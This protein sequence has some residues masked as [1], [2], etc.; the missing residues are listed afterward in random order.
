M[1]ANSWSWLRCAL[2]PIIG[3]NKYCAKRP[4]TLGI[5]HHLVL[6]NHDFQTKN[7]FCLASARKANLPTAVLRSSHFNITKFHTNPSRPPMDFPASKHC[8]FNVYVY[9]FLSWLNTFWHWLGSWWFMYRLQLWVVVVFALA[10]ETLRIW[11]PNRTL[12]LTL[13]ETWTQLDEA[14]TS[15]AVWWWIHLGKDTSESLGQMW[16]QKT[17]QLKSG[18]IVLSK[19]DVRTKNRSFWGDFKSRVTECGAAICQA[20][21]VRLHRPKMG[22]KIGY[23]QEIG[24]SKWPNDMQNVYWILWPQNRGLDFCVVGEWT[25]AVPAFSASFLSQTHLPWSN[26][27][28][29]HFFR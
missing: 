19:S 7:R 10:F 27:W 23:T 12:Q 22:D 3:H 13:L 2:P 25:G 29:P 15:S 17:N 20:L 1:K 5:L 9:T 18:K 28:T 16:S 8:F 6:G 14:R 21:R 4:I 24:V 26:G 11:N